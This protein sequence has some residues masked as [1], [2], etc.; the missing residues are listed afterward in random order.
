MERDKHLINLRPPIDNILLDTTEEIERFQNKT[1]R[2]IL[3]FQ[4]ELFIMLFLNSIF[5]KKMDFHKKD[6]TAKVRIIKDTLK[7]DNKLKDAILYSV[8]A[9]MTTEELTYLYTSNSSIKKRITSMVTERLIDQL[10]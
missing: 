3:K 6:E 9:L 2:P 8:I 5:I 1:L 10:V 4:N 7:K